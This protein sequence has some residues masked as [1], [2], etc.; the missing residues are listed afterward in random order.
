MPND[1]S[2][3]NPNV[4]ILVQNKPLATEIEADLVSVLVSE[5]LEAPGMFELRLITWD[6]LKQEMTWVVEQ[7]I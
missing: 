4:K 1:S 5:D 6:L 7:I 2:L 3:L